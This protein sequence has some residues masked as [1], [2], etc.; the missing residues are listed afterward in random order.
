MRRTRGEEEELEEVEETCYKLTL[1]HDRIIMVDDKE[2]LYAFITDVEG[3]EVVGV[4]GKEIFHLKNQIG[5]SCLQCLPSF[6]LSTVLYLE[7]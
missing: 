2:K 7:S 4:V 1:P 6:G 3:E 5:G